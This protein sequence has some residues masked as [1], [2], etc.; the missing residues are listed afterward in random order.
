MADRVV[1][2][3]YPAGAGLRRSWTTLTAA[4]SVWGS[5]SGVGIASSV[6]SVKLPGP[7]SLLQASRLASKTNKEHV[8]EPEKLV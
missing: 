5:M 7:L 4:K 3:P 1:R 8:N 6:D 2:R